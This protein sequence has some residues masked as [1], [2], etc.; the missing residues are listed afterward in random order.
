[1]T[2]NYSNKRISS[3]KTHGHPKYK[4]WKYISYILRKILVI[5]KGNNFPCFGICKTA[6]RCTRKRSPTYIY[7]PGIAPNGFIGYK[8]HH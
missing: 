3:P 5:S 2:L 8:V 6:S 4:F 1:M 7:F